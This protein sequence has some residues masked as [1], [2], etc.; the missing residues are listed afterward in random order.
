MPSLTE[1]VW[2][3][4]NNSLLD[5]LQHA[6]LN[7]LYSMVEELKPVEINQTKVVVANPRK[8][9]TAFEIS[10]VIIRVNL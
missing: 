6:L 10:I 3:S 5:T 2:E 9:K 1:C 7:R 4:Q 8:S